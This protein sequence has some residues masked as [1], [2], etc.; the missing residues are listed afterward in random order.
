M[1]I[2]GRKR[3]K[4]ENVVR[5]RKS[6]NPGSGWSSI[7]KDGKG[8]ISMLGGVGKLKE[9]LKVVSHGEKGV[10]KNHSEAVPCPRVE[11]VTL[12]LSSENKKKLTIKG[13]VQGGREGGGQELDFIGG[14][15]NIERIAFGR[16]RA[17]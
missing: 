1:P 7:L 8:T 16:K 15:K 2:D 11:D 12:I 3:R 6:E 9:K 13:R 4:K 14:E 5:K 17:K 10:R